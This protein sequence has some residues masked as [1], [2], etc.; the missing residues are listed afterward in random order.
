MKRLILIIIGM[1]VCTSTMAALT[2]EKHERYEKQYIIHTNVGEHISTYQPLV[3][4]LNNAKRDEVTLIIIKNNRGG[5]MHTLMQITNAIHRSDGL[6]FIRLKGYAAS[7]A[8]FLLFQ[9]DMATLPHTSGVLFHNIRY[10]NQDGKLVIPS[11]SNRATPYDV[12]VF[13]STMSWFLKTGVRELLT[14][15]EWHDLLDGKDIII[16]GK[17]ICTWAKV[18]NVLR[19][20]PG[21]YC[22]VKGRKSP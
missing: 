15:K 17:R 3:D 13:N 18:G 12:T 14:K 21:E 20:N 6:V 16:R 5:Y 7:A 10:V 11:K 9:G 22:L 2:V 19:N 8:A 1:L 4:K